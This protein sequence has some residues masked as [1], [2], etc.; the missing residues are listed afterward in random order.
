MTGASAKASPFAVAA[1]APV[2]LTRSSLATLGV[3]GL[4]VFRQ[5]AVQRLPGLGEDRAGSCHLRIGS[6][7][8]DLPRGQVD[9][10]DH[11]A[12]VDHG[13]GSAAGHGR[14]G[15]VQLVTVL[16]DV[17]LALLGQLVGAPSALS[18]LLLN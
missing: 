2:D 14:P 15:L 16:G 11:R 8:D 12:H 10:M 4:V 7:A 17:L 6:G 18:A 9:L 1:P 13:A 5:D 3:R